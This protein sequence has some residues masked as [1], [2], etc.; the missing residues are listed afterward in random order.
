M[1]KKCYKCGKFAG[2]LPEGERMNVV[3]YPAKQITAEGKQ[4]FTDPEV[5][6]YLCDS[7]LEDN[8]DKVIQEL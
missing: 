2:D 3:K 7:D 8:Q 1:L 5:I 6:V 4:I